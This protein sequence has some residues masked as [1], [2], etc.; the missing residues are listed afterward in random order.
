MYLYSYPFIHTF[1]SGVNDS[2]RIL[3]YFQKSFLLWKKK[4]RAQWDYFANLRIQNMFILLLCL[5]T[6]M[7]SLSVTSICS[8]PYVPSISVFLGSLSK[9]GLNRSDFRYLCYGEIQQYL[10]KTA[11]IYFYLESKFVQYVQGL[12]WEWL[13]IYMM[14]KSNK[15]L[16]TSFLKFLRDQWWCTHRTVVWC[17]RGYHPGARI[18]H[19]STPW[20]QTIKDAVNFNQGSNR[21]QLNASCMISVTGRDKHGTRPQT[22]I[23][24]VNRWQTKQ[25]ITTN[26]RTLEETL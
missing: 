2:D 7:L 15:S 5:V 9:T 26:Q 14:M 21:V 17:W 1:S 6:S 12:I 25:D 10:K 19:W 20:T 18:R 11:F 16:K 4:Y 22:C 23:L 3:Q 13:N 24:R 8:N